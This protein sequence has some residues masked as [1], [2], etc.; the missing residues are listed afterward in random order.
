VA[1]FIK[2]PKIFV[3]FSNFLWSTHPLRNH[4]YKLSHGIAFK[5]AGLQKL[6]RLISFS[7]LRIRAL[8]NNK[9]TGNVWN[10][11]LKLLMRNSSCM[12]FSKGDIKGRE[13]CLIDNRLGVD[14]KSTVIL[15]LKQLIVI[16]IGIGGI[17]QEDYLQAPAKGVSVARSRH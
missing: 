2:V 7:F 5:D 3:K 10:E 15:R 13:S 11:L 16:P 17:I 4:S 1:H 8:Y 6:K 14:K 12:Y 9:L